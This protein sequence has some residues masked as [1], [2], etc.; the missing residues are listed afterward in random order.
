MYN[1]DTVDIGAYKDIMEAGEN[2]SMEVIRT[3]TG[4]SMVA[5]DSSRLSELAMGIVYDRAIILSRIFLERRRVGT[6]TKIF[7][8]SLDLC[9]KYNTRKFIVQSVVTS[10]MASWCVSHGMSP[11]MYSS[12]EQDGVI[13]GDYSLD[14]HNL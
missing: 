3:F 9:K 13:Y 4:F 11:V 12:Y 10:E 6:M 5:E 14:I 7:N 8:L 1:F 2:T